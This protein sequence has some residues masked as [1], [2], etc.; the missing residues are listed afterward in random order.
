MRRRWMSLAHHLDSLSGFGRLLQAFALKGET[1]KLMFTFYS[2]LLG[3][4]LCSSTSEYMKREVA[5]T[6]KIDPFEQINTL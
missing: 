4:L 3:S 1:E 2:C 6:K 5:K